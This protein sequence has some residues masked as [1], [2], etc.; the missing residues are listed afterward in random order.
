MAELNPQENRIW[1]AR[2]RAIAAHGD[3]LPLQLLDNAQKVARRLG[4]ERR[5]AQH[6]LAMPE[7]ADFLAPGE[8]NPRGISPYQEV[9][10]GARPSRRDPKTVGA[11]LDNF[12]QLHG[13][14]EQLEVAQ[15]TQ[16]WPD[17]VGENFAAN[18]QVI[19]FSDAGVL[20]LQAKTVSWQTQVKALLAVLD[21]RLAEVLG[22]GVVKEIVVNGPNTRSW[23]HGPRVVPGR[24]PRDTYD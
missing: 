5:R 20:T 9:G 2:Q 13:W 17:I 15:V 23:R 21:K 7:T 16:R 10:S 24:G 1:Q 12:V 11:L 14:K 3:A 22:E 6:K 18:C 4:F 8:E 19:E